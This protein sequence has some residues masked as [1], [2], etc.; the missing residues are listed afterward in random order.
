M[1]KYNWKKIVINT[2]WVLAGIGTFV[3]L[4]A[5]MQ[6]KNHKICMDVKIEITGVERHMF[7][8][9]KDVMEILTAAGPITGTEISMLNLRQMESV[10]EK[11]PWVRNAE[12]FLDNNQVLQVRIEERQPVARVFTLGGN[13]F[14]LDSATLRLPLSEKLSARVPV[15]TG[16]PSDK[17]ALAK[18]DSALLRN[19][20]AIGQY[21][22]AD[23]FW[24]AQTA[25]IDI[26]TQHGFEMVPVIGDHTVVLGN[27]D[28]VDQKL[29]RLYTFYKKAWLQNGMNT[30]EKLDVQYDNQVVAIRKG[31]SKA[32]V[33]SA[34]AHQLMEGMVAASVARLADSIPVSTRL[35]PVKDT[36][37]KPAPVKPAVKENTKT[38]SAA[39]ANNKTGNIP[40]T[41]GKKT[42]HR[43][44]AVKKPVAKTKKQPKAVM[45]KNKK[46]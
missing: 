6:K 36:T 8:D 10:V 42:K 43:K 32:W 38:N 37:V 31:A 19:I 16:F 27:A 9:E 29:K 23:S 14:Y 21:I 26:T 12:M 41:N 20:V 24:M 5:A 11:N 18:P 35:K 39:L 22:L 40:L 45:D 33:D 28:E 44:Q 17:R 1:R 46:P 15:F 3:L 2:L 7:I 25:Q 13:S 34:R 30:Y 4:G